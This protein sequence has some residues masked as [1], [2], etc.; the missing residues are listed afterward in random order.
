[1]FVVQDDIYRR[2]TDLSAPWEKL[3]GAL[4]YVSTYDGVIMAGANA[5][6]QIYFA[7]FSPEDALKGGVNWRQ[8]PGSLKNVS[9]HGGPNAIYGTNDGVKFL[10]FLFS[11]RVSFL[12]TDLPLDRKRLGGKLLFFPLFFEV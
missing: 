4:K 11:L 5:A 1:M 12:G 6:D 3:P 2:P 7:G 9:V 10:S 8:V